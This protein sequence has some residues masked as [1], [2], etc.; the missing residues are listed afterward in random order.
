MTGVHINCDVT[1]LY[2]GQFATGIPCKFFYLFFLF[3]QNN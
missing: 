2:I 1:V 3:N